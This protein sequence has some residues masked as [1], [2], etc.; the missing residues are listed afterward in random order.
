M[1]PKAK[2][3][4]PEGAEAL[5]QR[6]GGTARSIGSRSGKAALGAT[7]KT[8]VGDAP[9]LP[10]LLIGLGAY[11][12]WFAVKYWR[13]QSVHWPSDPVKSV[14]QGHGLPAHTEAATV[15]A[16][17]G[18]AIATAQAEAPGPSAGAGGT[19]AL[20]ASGAYSASQLE[21]I[22]KLAGGSPAK[23]SF[24]A[25]VA[26]AE[27]GGRPKITSPNPDGG[28]NVGLWQLDTK[29]KGAGHTVAQLQNPSTNAVVTVAATGNGT[30]WSAWSDPFIAAHG[31]SGDIGTSNKPG[32]SGFLP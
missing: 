21:S 20:P 1:P 24:A 25:G 9:V 16:E 3:R 10:L 28:T 23:A 14:L 31:I 6:A 11:F 30:D 27:S 8:P 15:A 17:L 4:V 29:G 22:W 26:L 12:M 32:P 2:T 13:D 18:Q 19:P 5:R 7:V